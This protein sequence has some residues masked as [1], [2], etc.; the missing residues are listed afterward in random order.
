MREFMA[1]LRDWFRRDQ[2]DRELQEELQFHQ[3]Q[4]QRDAVGFDN[5]LASQRLGNTTSIR[6]AARERWSIPWLDN[7]QQDV[8][9]AVRGLIRN[10]AF[11]IV[12]VLT[13]A[14][15]LGANAS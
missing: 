4:L 7:L 11:T 3:Q 1:R 10:P 15:G 13:L 5:A 2:L 8:R 12:V 14:L 9:Y 6:E